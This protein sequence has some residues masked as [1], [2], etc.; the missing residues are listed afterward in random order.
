LVPEADF[1]DSG[2]G[3]HLT[4]DIRL[5]LPGFY[6]S[7]RGEKLANSGPVVCAVFTTIQQGA[8]NGLVDTP[9]SSWNWTGRR[10]Q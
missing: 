4:A 8:R 10:S 1:A 2:I 3:K 6:L 9:N 5:T 7:P